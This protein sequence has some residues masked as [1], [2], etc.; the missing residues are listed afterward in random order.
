MSEAALALLAA[1][2]RGG[3]EPARLD[4]EDPE[5]ISWH[6][7][8]RERRGVSIAEM[9]RAQAKATHRLLAAVLSPA[10]H[11]RVAAIAGLE[12]VLDEIEGGRRGRHAGDYW[13]AIFGDPKGDRWGW[14]FEG[15]HVSVNISVAGGRISATPFFL[16]ANPAT[17][18]DDG[19]T[20]LRPLGPEEDLAYDLLASLDGDQRERAVVSDAAPEDILTG[21]RPWAETALGAPAGLAGA[22]LRPEQRRRLRALAA[23]Y[24][25]RLTVD[26]ARSR[27]IDLDGQLD[28]LHFAWAGD[29]RR[30]PGAAHYYR[31]QG[32]TFL[33]ELDNTQ[34][35]ANHVHSVWRDRQDDFGGG[36]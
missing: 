18:G 26:L 7:T 2:G 10:A 25:K 34:N 20:V 17:V 19:G 33:V 9:D 11:A 21:E 23:T 35:G 15:H 14:R 28:A 8:P 1:L 36:L 4:Y 12:D 31:L 6:Y 32:P 3:G 22:E 30:R 16:G 24:P 29:Q 13:A 27:L 5:R